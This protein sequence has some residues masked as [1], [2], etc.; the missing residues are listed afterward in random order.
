MCDK[1]EDVINPK[2]GSRYPQ[3]HAEISDRQREKH[4]FPTEEFYELF[5]M[6]EKFR[7]KKMVDHW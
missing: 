2:A 3:T 4:A 6:L 1:Y 7:L 5:V